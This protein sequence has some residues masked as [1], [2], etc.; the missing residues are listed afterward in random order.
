M[1]SLLSDIALFVPRLFVGTRRYRMPKGFSQEKILC[2]GDFLVRPG[3]SGFS[4]VHGLLEQIRLLYISLVD[5]LGDAASVAVC[6]PN[7]QE[8]RS[9]L[10]ANLAVSMAIDTECKVTLVDLN[11]RGP[12][13]P[14]LIDVEPQRGICDMRPSNSALDFLTA[15]SIPNLD[16]LATGTSPVNPVEFLNT[17]TLNQTIAELNR[18]ERFVIIDTPAVNNFI[19]ARI[20]AEMTTG[21]VTVVKLGSTKRFQLAAYYRKLQNCRMLGVVCNY[22]EY[23]IPSWLYR[24]V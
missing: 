2:E 24:L 19:D 1:M 4:T 11:L 20:V 18:N 23:W 12:S 6:S 7:R 16:L 5:V 10:A 8:G 15:T 22:N 13:L 9:F 14:H 21:V 17:N 3:Q